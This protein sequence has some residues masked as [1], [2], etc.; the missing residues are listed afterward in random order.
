MTNKQLSDRIENIDDRLVQQAQDLPNYGK[1]HRVTNIRRLATLVAVAAL[2]ASCFAIGALAFSKE[3][4]VEIEVPVQQELLDLTDIG[5]TLILPDSWKG[6]Y[7]METNEYGD[8]LVYSIPIREAFCEEWGDEDSGG[9]VFYIHKWP[10]QITE[11]QWRNTDGEWNYAGNRYIMTTKDGTYLLYYASDVQCTMD[12]V[13]EYQKMKT[14]ISE[15][16][17]IIN[18]ALS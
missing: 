16:R 9:M 2:M 1:K 18:S 3:T 6:K 10:Q 8:Y 12:T 14:E 4:I 5:I 13:D 7:A 17:F 11:E 15:I